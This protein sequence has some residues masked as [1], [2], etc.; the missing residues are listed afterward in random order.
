MSSSSSIELAPGAEVAG[1]R[2]EREIGRGPRGIV[3]EAT[4]AGLQRRVALKLLAGRGE[5]GRTLAWPEHPNVVSM[6]AA[7]SWAGG[8]YVA[9]RLVRGPSLAQLCAAAQSGPRRLREILAQVAAALD[10]A[11]AVG[12][13]HG[14]VTAGNVLIDADGRALLS[15]FGQVPNATAAADRAAFAALVAACLGEQAAGPSDS[16]AAIVGAAAPAERE[17]PLRRRRRHPAWALLAVA[18]ALAALALVG[19]GD[20]GDAPG[21]PGVLPSARVLGSS[22]AAGATRSVDCHG[23]PPSGGSQGCTVVQARLPGRPLTAR[24][25]GAVRRWVVQGARG[26][27]ALQIV[28]RRG[29]R[30]VAV[31]RSRFE[32]VTGAGPQ[33]FAAD[34]QIRAGDRVGLAL[35]PGA[36]LGVRSAPRGASTE[37]WLGPLSLS[38]RP[39]D[40]G[41]GSGL[42]REIALRAEYV[43]GARP[44]A[45]GLL[46]GR[47]AERAPAGRVLQA[48]DVEL[49][50][51][52]RRTVALVALP[53]T[54]AIDLLDGARRVARLP[55]PDADPRGEL[56]EFATYGEPLP[57]LRWRNR[58]GAVVKHEYVAQPRALT[59]RG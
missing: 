7:G 28:R 53:G 3:F 34:L 25:G 50:A 27:L 37:R 17:P 16:A 47:R 8:S 41:P 13:A 43:P 39:V 57:I 2:L 23:G 22:L 58:G 38:P 4:Q 18:P 14:A 42:D 11:H 40:L 46:T 5:P 10:A 33:T 52:R 21:V 49:P 54:V 51:G 12:I 45:G 24:T 9:M 56:L 15:D 59:Q 19:G 29:T 32:R 48:R 6:Y 55:V 26:E 31:A 36:A 35:A 1:F 44:A 20:D 30:Y